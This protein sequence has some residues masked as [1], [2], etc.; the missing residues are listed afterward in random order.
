MNKPLSAN[1][2]V[3]DQTRRVHIVR[4]VA[5]RVHDPELLPQTANPVE[6]V[7]RGCGCRGRTVARVWDGSQKEPR[8]NAGR[9]L[10][11]SKPPRRN[12]SRH[13]GA[14]WG[15]FPTRATWRSADG[16]DNREPL[17]VSA[18]SPDIPRSGASLGT[19][20][21]SRHVAIGG[22][23]GQPRTAPEFP[24]T[25]RV[26]TSSGLDGLGSRLSSTSGST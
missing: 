10:S 4:W 6:L 20:P 18:H 21:N 7:H 11:V 14:S 16:R 2:L 8:I 12:G 19:V 3:K 1:R 23:E 24:P 17:R 15:R 22:W 9:W 5:G 26:S 13:P 25:P